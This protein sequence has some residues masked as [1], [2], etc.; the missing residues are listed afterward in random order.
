[1]HKHKP[2]KLYGFVSGFLRSLLDDSIV[3][4]CTHTHT[5]AHT[6]MHTHTHTPQTNTGTHM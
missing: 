5:N 3:D 1:M 4:M 2:I 6:H